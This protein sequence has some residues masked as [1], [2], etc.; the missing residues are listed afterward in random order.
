MTPGI[1]DEWWWWWWWWWL[2]LWQWFLS[3]N[4]SFWSHQIAVRRN[5]VLV[6]RLWDSVIYIYI[7]IRRL[8]DIFDFCGL[9]SHQNFDVTPWI[10]RYSV[11]SPWYSWYPKLYG[12]D[13]NMKTLNRYVQVIKHRFLTNNEFLIIMISV[14]R[15]ESIDIL[16][17]WSDLDRIRIL[18]TKTLICKYW[19]N[20]KTLK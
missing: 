17:V 4:L 14:F 10:D 6:D 8:Q 18:S 16:S 7:H 11:H 5:P 2:L 9:M 1:H 12:H 20:Q 3:E 19:N 15:H 13:Y